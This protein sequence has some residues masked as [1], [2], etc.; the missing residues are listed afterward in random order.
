M[1]HTDILRGPQ[2]RNISRRDAFATGSRT[3]DGSPS[4]QHRRH[5]QIRCTAR[6]RDMTRFHLTWLV[7]IW[8]DLCVCIIITFSI[9]ALNKCMTWLKNSVLRDT[10]HCSVACL[11]Y[12]RHK[13]YHFLSEYS[14]KVHDIT[15]R[16]SSTRHDLLLHGITHLNMTQVVS[17]PTWI[18][19]KIAWYDSMTH[20]MWHNVLPCGVS[21]LYTTFVVVCPPRMPSKSV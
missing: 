10:T 21:H 11:I 15:Q 12:I 14:R 17:R 18:L 19:S 16:P 1:Q 8:H 9:N 4:P 5:C 6:M 20:F 7:S 13:S 2:A 3:F